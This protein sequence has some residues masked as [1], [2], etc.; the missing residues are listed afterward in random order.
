MPHPLEAAA[1]AAMEAEAKTQNELTTLRQQL[2]VSEERSSILQG[3]VEQ[4]EAELNN[5][6][7]RSDHYLRWNAE[8]TMQM[9]NINMFVQDAMEQARINVKGNGQ[10]N[11]MEAAQKAIEQAME[12]RDEPVQRKEPELG[13]PG[14]KVR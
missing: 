1:K 9:H 5:A 12:T 13:I 6:L 3:R 8:I 7:T 14:N 10:K 11:V 4:L 2:R